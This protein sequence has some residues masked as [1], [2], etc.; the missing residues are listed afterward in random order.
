MRICSN[1]TCNNELDKQPKYCSRSCAAQVN[2]RKY[3]K[4]PKEGGACE[5]CGSAL[6]AQHTRFCSIEC[7]RRPRQEAIRD[8]VN[9]ITSPQKGKGVLPEWAR[10]YL[11][12]LAGNK[13]SK[14]SWA[15]PNPKLGRPILTIEH[16][17]GNW[18]NN[19]ID[20]L[21]VLCYNCHTLTDTFGSL[22]K[23]NGTFTKSRGF[24]GRH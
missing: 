4:R 14:C 7:M 11:L 9:G 2:N 21:E 24:P 1:P 12:D 20:N 5:S 3:P 23:G 16:K 15:V 6:P 19:R 22:N 13:C 10:N 8:W 17:D 18:L